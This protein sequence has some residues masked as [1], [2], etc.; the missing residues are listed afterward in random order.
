[1]STSACNQLQLDPHLTSGSPP[2]P[3]K[4]GLTE[5]HRKRLSRTVTP[6]VAGSS[7]SLP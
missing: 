7:P 1:M 5:S 2:P 4:T 3:A 6:E